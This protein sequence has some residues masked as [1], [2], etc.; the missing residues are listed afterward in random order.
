MVTEVK[1]EKSFEISVPRALFEFR[2]GNVIVT[3]APY[4]VTTDGQRFLIN[5]IVDES[6]GA[7]LTTVVNWQAGLKK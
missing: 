4:T 5:T 6:S 1:N 7:P 2:S 3:S